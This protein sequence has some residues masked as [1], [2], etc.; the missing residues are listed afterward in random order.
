MT[1]KHKNEYSEKCT[2]LC[3]KPKFVKN[4]MGK[5]VFPPDHYAVTAAMAELN[6]LQ[7]RA[8]LGDIKDESP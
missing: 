3:F 4:K 6:S 2:V 8:G 1:V 7:R 5:V